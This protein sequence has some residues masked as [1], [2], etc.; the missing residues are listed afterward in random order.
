MKIRSLEPLEWLELQETF[1]AEFSEALPDPETT[2]IMGVEEDGKIIG[3]VHIEE[4][5]IHIRH[6]FV[7]TE[8]RGDGTAEALVDHVRTLF[9]N[10]GKRAHLVATTPFAEQL[11]EQAGMK[12]LKGTLW[13]G[14]GT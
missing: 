5:A 2:R 3:F 11:A 4:V 10:A 6:I 1:I 8:H 14:N 7:N 13:E 12:K 9:R